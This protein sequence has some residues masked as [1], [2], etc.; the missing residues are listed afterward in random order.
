MFLPLALSSVEFYSKKRVR[1]KFAIPEESL[2][3]DT[4]YFDTK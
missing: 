1:D 4:W 2:F 3:Q